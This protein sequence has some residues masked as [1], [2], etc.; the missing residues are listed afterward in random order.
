M[1]KPTPAPDWPASW[2]LSYQFDLVEVFGERADPGYTWSY[3]ER[4]RRVLE[5]L[6]AAV[7]SGGAILDIAA[8]QGNFSI[9]LAEL[10][11]RVTWNDLREE[12]AGYVRLKHERGSLEFLPGNCFELAASGAFDAVIITE[13][14]E[15][16]AHPDEF[17][18]K[19]AALVRP[20]GWVFM[21]TPNGAYFR[22]PLP[23]FA[24]CPDPSAYEAV[25]FKPDADGHIFL[26]HDDEV[27]L[28]AAKAGLE[29]HEL[30]LFVNPLT[31]GALRTRR[32]LPWLPPQLVQLGERLTASGGGRLFRRLN[33]HLMAVLRKPGGPA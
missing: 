5:A 30:R 14:I 24:D 18:A 1:R 32:L 3:R 6:R 28:L 21:T 12:L 31:R 8:A 2:K 22:N 4:Q 25:Q 19:A 26:L 11:Y 23:R 10:G 17:L 20:G 7:P 9:T 16:V 27:R 33:L 29:V 15:H 13:I